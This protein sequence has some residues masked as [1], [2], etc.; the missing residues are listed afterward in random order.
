M[1]GKHVIISSL[2]LASTTLL[3]SCGG[4]TQKINYAYFNTNQA[5]VDSVDKN[6]QAQLAETAA[7]VDQS[8]QQLSAIK[9]ATHPGIPMSAPANAAQLG[10]TQMVSINWHGPA[11]SI[12][13]QIAK[14]GHYKLRILGTR[15]QIPVLVNINAKNVPLATVL[16]NVSYQVATKGT[17]ETYPKDRVI[18]LRYKENA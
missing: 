4:S 18:E 14:V 6:A 11:E 3:S 17:I 15:P 8:L 13:K 16:R 1:K 10:L 12:L 9:V 5:P 7:S 2:L